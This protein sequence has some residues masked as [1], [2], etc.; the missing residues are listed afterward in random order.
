MPL[1]L[2]LAAALSAAVS[3]G[4]MGIAFI[5]FLRRMRFCEPELPESDASGE[6]SGIRLR[7]T[8][9]GMLLM[10]GMLT[11]IAVAGAFSFGMGI[12][13]RTAL[14][15]HQDISRTMLCIAAA[16]VCAAAG[17]LTDFR[18]ILRVPQFRVSPLLRALCVCLFAAAFV[19][20]LKPESSMDFVYFKWNA[21]WMKIPAAA[22]LMTVFCCSASEMKE[23]PEGTELVTGGILFLSLTIQFV[24]NS[25]VL[26]GICSMAAAGACLGCMVWCFYPAKCRLGKTGAFWLWGSLAALCTASGMY[27]TEILFSVVFLLNTFPRC[28]RSKGCCTLQQHLKKDGYTEMQ[29]ILIFA[30]FSAFCGILA[31]LL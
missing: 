7:P 17:M 16:A 18:R 6:A 8:L 27:M 21:G 29:R 2:Q 30:A 9:G 12:L 23:E 14:S 25:M 24:R 5:P 3:S 15:V 1:W 10:F 22:A 31:V 28:L 19:L 11:G 20:L 4:V 26:N 13:D